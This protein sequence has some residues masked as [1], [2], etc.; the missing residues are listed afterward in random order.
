M[1]V[2]A[3]TLRSLHRTMLTIRLFEQRVSREFRTGEIPGFVH[4][5][6]GQEAVA[7]GVC[8]NLRD[9]D[10][11]TSTHRGHGHCI[12]KGCNL[13]AMMAEIYGR[14]DGLCKGR[15]GS[16]HIADFSVGMLGANGVV[17][18]GANLAVG[19]GDR[20]APAWN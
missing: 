14:E 3:A 10:Y 1:E 15:G 6:V 9:D 12:A 8:A 7:A 13:D 19:G 2:D 17:G 20:R 18:G 4:M 11:V 5:Y 16:M